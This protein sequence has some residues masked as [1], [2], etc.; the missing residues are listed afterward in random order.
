MPAT[1]A[2]TFRQDAS[3]CLGEIRALGSETWSVIALILPLRSYLSL[4][5]LLVQDIVFQLHRFITALDKYHKDC[6]EV[7][8]E[9]DIFPIEVDLTLPALRGTG[10]QDQDEDDDENEQEDNGEDL[11]H[12]DQR[13]N[14]SHQRQITEDVDLLNI[15]QWSLGQCNLFFSATPLVLFHV[16]Y[17]CIS[18]R[19]FTL[20]FIV[21]RCLLLSSRSVPLFSLLICIIQHLIYHDEL[22]CDLRGFYSWPTAS[23]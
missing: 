20:I 11:F 5:V 9:A 22:G 16:Q 7:M 12:D 19:R 14:V 2:W 10:Q 13:G 18:S 21:F 8:K 3:R 6:N 17:L 1:R 23:P 4:S 15:G